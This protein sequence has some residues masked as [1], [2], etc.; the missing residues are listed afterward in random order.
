[1]LASGRWHIESVRPEAG[2]DADRVRQWLAALAGTPVDTL[3]ETSFP[4]RVAR[5]WVRHGAVLQLAG[6]EVHVASPQRL[7]EVW[8]LTTAGE[9]NAATAVGRDFLRRRL[10]LVAAGRVVAWVSL[11]SPLRP[12]VAVQLQALSALGF[13][14]I[15]LFAESIG[16]PAD[17]LPATR[18][19]GLAVRL[20]PLESEADD[21][22]LRSDWLAGALRD[23]QPLVIVHTVLRDLVPPDSLIPS[24]GDAGSHGILLGEPLGSVVA[25]RRTAQRVHP[26]LRLQKVTAV[27]ANAGLMTAAALRWLPPMAITLLHHAHALLLLLDSLRM[28]SLAVSPAV[29]E[30]DNPRR[31]SA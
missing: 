26:R 19:H 11:V 30:P 15:A 14:R 1:M 4:D 20:R 7:L 29:A 22:G 16:E 8:S 25:A 9:A 2:G 5:Q 17:P 13:E 3:A 31:K 21:A 12:A 27:A 28:E 10:A 6:H 24:D 18:A 23:G